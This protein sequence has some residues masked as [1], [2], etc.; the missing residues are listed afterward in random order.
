MIVY[1]IARGL[2]WRRVRDFFLTA[3]CQRGVGHLSVSYNLSIYMKWEYNSACCFGFSIV[4]SYFGEIL[5]QFME[6][7]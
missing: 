4:V 1:A 3:K 7:L 2:V 5:I 6:K